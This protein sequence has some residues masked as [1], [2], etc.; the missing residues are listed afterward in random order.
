MSARRVDTIKE[1]ASIT[2]ENIVACERT[3]ATL[4]IKQPKALKQVYVSILIKLCVDVGGRRSSVA[5]TLALPSIQDQNQDDVSRTTTRVKEV[6]DDEMLHRIKVEPN[7]I[8]DV[9]QFSSTLKHSIDKADSDRIL[10]TLQHKHGPLA[11][12]KDGWC[13]LHYTARTNN[14][15]I[16]GILIRPESLQTIQQAI[17]MYNHTGATPLQSAASIVSLGTVRV[18]LEAG[19]KPHATDH[20]QRSSLFMASERNHLQVIKLLLLSG[21]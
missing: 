9:S 8:S 21:V 4:L 5:T 13:A 10:E 12:D 16:C 18:L 17:D 7:P 1:V 2:Q 14:E 20:H 15:D 11:Q 3:L 19:V 6:E